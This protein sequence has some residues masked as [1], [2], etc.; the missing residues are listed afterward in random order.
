MSSEDAIIAALEQEGVLLRGGHFRLA[1][2]RHADSFVV[3]NKIGENP[4]LLD[5]LAARTA[6]EAAA[7]EPDVV[8]A[9]ATGAVAFGHAVAAHLGDVLQREVRFAYAC[10]PFVDGTP[11]VLKRGY[12]AAIR[13]KRVLCLSTS[14]NAAALGDLVVKHGGQN[15]LRLNL[16]VDRMY[17]SRPRA[18]LDIVEDLMA[19]SAARLAAQAVIVEA[20]DDIPLGHWLARAL[21]VTSV[22]AERA[23]DDTAALAIP[24]HLVPLVADRRA[25]NVEDVITTAKSLLQLREA[26]I[27]TGGKLVRERGIWNRGTFTDPLLRSLVNHTLPSYE[28]GDS[29]PPCQAGVPIS[30]EYGRGPE[31]E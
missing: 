15:L 9:A 24:E 10:R 28:P 4:E 2:G 1:S 12:P 8:V 25:C 27:R 17:V 31:P 18:A 19:R 6:N 30:R 14:G 3:K 11:L 16:D 5:L 23:V 21:M 13:G 7:D 22:Y 29:C 26:T 20:N